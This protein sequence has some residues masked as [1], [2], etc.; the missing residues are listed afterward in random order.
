MSVEIEVRS[1]S[2]HPGEWEA[3]AQWVGL[4]MRIDALPPAWAR[5]A[6][7]GVGMTREAAEA[8]AIQA[9]QVGRATK[10]SRGR[11]LEARRV[12]P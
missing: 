8:A 5:V 1:R 10:G 3:Q 2:A 11:W 6:Y 4:T 7:T 9:A 12:A